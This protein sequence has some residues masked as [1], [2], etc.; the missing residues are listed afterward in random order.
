MKKVYQIKSVIS[1]NTKEKGTLYLSSYKLNV[2]RKGEEHFQSLVIHFAPKNEKPKYIKSLYLNEN[3]VKALKELQVNT[4]RDSRSILSMY[5]NYL[6]II[7]ITDSIIDDYEL[8][9]NYKVESIRR[10]IFRLKTPKPKHEEKESLSN[11]YKDNDE[12]YG[13][14]LVLTKCL[15]NP[16]Y[17]NGSLM[18]RD[19]PTEGEF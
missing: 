10:A 5:N 3:E 2:A 9:Q 1:E 15:D 8:D 7:C 12:F 16:I 6:D 13:V 4:I 18:P 17:T 19:L 11:D 14:R